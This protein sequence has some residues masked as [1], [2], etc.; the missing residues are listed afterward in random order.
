MNKNRFETE[1]LIL[2]P[3]SVEDA[4]L[5]L[6]SMNTKEFIDFVGDRNVRT[7]EDAETYIKEKHLPQIEKLGYGNFTIIEKKNGSK[8]GH[9]P[10]KCVS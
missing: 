2:V 8:I 7:I 6:K 1:R 5:V 4:E 9:Y 10:V 3:S